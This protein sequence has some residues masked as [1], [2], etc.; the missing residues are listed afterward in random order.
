MAQSSILAPDVTQANSTDIVVGQNEFVTVSLYVTVGDIPDNADFM[1]FQKTPGSAFPLAAL[2][3][4]APLVIAAEGTYYV[5]RI[6][7]GNARGDT[8]PVAVGVF[9]EQGA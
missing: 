6:L 5:R 7:S 3:P 1:I 8:T 2:K 4:R 9:K